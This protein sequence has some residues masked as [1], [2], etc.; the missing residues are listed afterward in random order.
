MSPLLPTTD[1]HQTAHRSL[2]LL[3]ASQQRWYS[4]ASV[5][6]FCA[7]LHTL[8]DLS[9]QR[10]QES[11]HPPAYQHAAKLLQPSHRARSGWGVVAAGEACGPRSSDAIF[12]EMSRSAGSTMPAILP[13]ALQF[14]SRAPENRHSLPETLSCSNRLPGPAASARH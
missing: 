7:V 1:V 2:L 14:G 12:P 5:P 10:K 9:D 11:S 3:Q 13:S 4:P 6:L 8:L